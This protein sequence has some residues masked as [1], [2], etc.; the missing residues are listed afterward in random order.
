MIKG[1]QVINR[2]HVRTPSAAADLATQ[3]NFMMSLP[4]RDL[5]LFYLP[6]LYALSLYSTVYSIISL[7]SIAWSIHH[8]DPCNVRGNVARTFF[9]AGFILKWKPNFLVPVAFLLV[10]GYPLAFLGNSL[11]TVNIIIL[12][13][14]LVLF[15]ITAVILS[16][17][18]KING[19]PNPR[20]IGWRFLNCFDLVCADHC[21]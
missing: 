20:G 12:F 13:N 7:G 9:C 8:V 21:L 18:L 1:R 14:L 4:H 19:N 11:Q 6:K 17:H 16:Q 5:D 3:E 15:L 2:R 10:M